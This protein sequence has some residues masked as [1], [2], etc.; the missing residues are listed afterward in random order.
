VI[1][2]KNFSNLSGGKVR[3][4]TEGKGE[5]WGSRRH[6][7]KKTMEGSICGCSMLFRPTGREV[8]GCVKKRGDRGGEFLKRRVK[9]LGPPNSLS[10]PLG[11][12][13]GEK[14]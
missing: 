1:L 13:E 12:E 8:K 9:R 11:C 6:K 5:L 4:K 7:K 14:S 2:F 10:K 3:F